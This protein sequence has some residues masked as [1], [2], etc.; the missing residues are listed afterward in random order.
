MLNRL[1]NNNGKGSNAVINNQIKEL[2]AD[3]A[4]LKSD[5]DQEQ[6]DIAALDADLDTKVGKADL[7]SE[8]DTASLKANTAKIDTIESKDA[9]DVTINDN[10]NVNGNIA[11]TGK[12]SA[13]S[14]EANG[15]DI[16]NDYTQK[17][18]C[19]LSDASSFKTMFSCM[20]YISMRNP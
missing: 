9:N 6:I 15:V 14:F 1:N 7:A 12:V 13:T 20:S 2:Q 18:S 19:A 10:L 17:T 4:Q 11:A 3:V 5:V 8:V 16:V